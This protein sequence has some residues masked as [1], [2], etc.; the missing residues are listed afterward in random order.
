[1]GKLTEDGSIGYIDFSVN[2]LFK[3]YV[4]LVNN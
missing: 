1:M 3:R 2:I 4:L